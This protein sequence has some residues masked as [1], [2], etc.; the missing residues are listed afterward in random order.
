MSGIAGIFYRDGRPAQ[1][2]TIQAMVYAM[3]H[4]GPDGIDTWYEGSIALGHCMLHT[5]PESLH[6]RLPMISR[7][8]NLVLTADARID[9]RE[10]LMRVLGLRPSK[11]RPVTDCDLIMGAYQ[12]WGA[13][14]PEH[15]LGAFAFVVWDARRKRMLC[16]RDHLGVKPLYLYNQNASQFAFGSEI[17]AILALP[18]VECVIDETELGKSLA[19]LPRDLEKTVFK[20]VTKL[21]PAHKLVITPEKISVSKYWEIRP[22]DEALNLSP[23][24][25]ATRFKEHLTEAVAC[26][27]RSLHGVGSELSGGLDSSAVAGVAREI[28]QGRG[29]TLKTFSAV[30]DIVTDVDEREY[31][32]VFTKLSGVEPHF[33]P[34][35]SYGPLSAAEEIYEYL[36]DGTMAVGNSFIRWNLIRK[37]SE[38]DTRVLLTGTDGD[39][40]VM[41]GIE[42]LA[43][44]ACARDWSSFHHEATKHYERVNNENLS[45]ATQEAAFE[46]PV[47]NLRKCAYPYLRLWAIEGSF[48]KFFSSAYN[49]SK[50]FGISL[51]G[52]VREFWK[53]LVVPKYIFFKRSKVDNTSVHESINKDFSKR[54]RLKRYVKG[55]SKM[56]DR[57]PS[58]RG[59]QLKIFKSDLISGSLENANQLAAAWGVDIRHPY[60]DIRLIQYCLGLPPEDSLFDGWTRY[61]VRK[62]LQQTLPEKIRTRC[63]KAS[64]RSAF[65]FAL[66]THDRDKY[67]S[68]IDNLDSMHKYIDKTYI[69]S[70]DEDEDKISNVDM[71]LLSGLIGKE[72]WL[73]KIKQKYKPVAFSDGLK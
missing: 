73:N 46:S 58:V 55:Y 68:Y 52:I 56:Y 42:R 38:E 17:K 4:R 72:I 33:I 22:S 12:K 2:E 34:M 48:I 41:H 10:E 63:T 29:Q 47:Y 7:D 20:G 35:D 32:H 44:L 28:L 45:Y 65:H 14:C 59:Q 53:L 50:Y 49:I 60:M 19:W 25:R 40:T 1:P 5:T 18:G 6:D 13:A 43:E 51:I 67:E 31:I 9:N 27:V 69:E 37:A 61:I 8:G 15:L 11:D 24:E 30:Y 57:E 70:L 23:D 16:A 71:S 3:P 62:S 26:R 36:D 21:K 66:F 64:M 54:I 39:T